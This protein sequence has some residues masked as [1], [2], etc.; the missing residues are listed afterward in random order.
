MCTTIIVLSLSIL[1]HDNGNN[2]LYLWKV[3]LSQWWWV[4]TSVHMPKMSTSV[5]MPIMSNVKMKLEH[6]FYGAPWVT[7]SLPHLWQHSKARVL[8]KG[9]VKSARRPW[10]EVRMIS[11]SGSHPA[12]ARNADT[13]SPCSTKL[14][15]WVMKGKT[16]TCW[17]GHLDKSRQLI[18]KVQVLMSGFL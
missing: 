14:S 11:A 4:C 13:A 7:P 1:P 9:S 2:C 18:H 3:L 5:H 12:S 6:S 8:C 15:R 17:K 16:S 10:Q